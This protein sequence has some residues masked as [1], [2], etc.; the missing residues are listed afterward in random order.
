MWTVNLPFRLRDPQA[1]TKQSSNELPTRND[2][3][4]KR[5][6]AVLRGR[7]RYE[8]WS[9][10]KLTAALI[11]LAESKEPSQDKAAPANTQAD[12]EPPV[13]SE[14][15]LR[16]QTQQETTRICR[17]ADKEGWDDD[18]TLAALRLRNSVHPELERTVNSG[19]GKTQE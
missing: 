5:E 8:G 2:K 10:E 7:A 11:N 17:Q 6:A 1:L 16:R 14:A 15:A 12:S 19:P 3:Q 4:D 18:R 9:E 13:G